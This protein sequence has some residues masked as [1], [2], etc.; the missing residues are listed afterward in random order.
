MREN[1]IKVLEFLSKD[2]LSSEEQFLL[3]ELIKNDKEALSA[4]TLHNKVKNVVNCSSHISDEDIANYIL[5]K[6]NVNPD[7]IFS[8]SELELIE[9]HLDECERCSTAFT[10]LSLE[11]ENINNMFTAPASASPVKLKQNRFLFSFKTKFIKYAFASGLA[12]AVLCISLILISGLSTPKT[13]E[14]A[15]VNSN[16]LFYV[17][18]GRGSGQFQRGL[19]FLGNKDF[20]DAAKSFEQDITTNKDPETIF[21][22][23]YILGLTYLA[24][25]SK[26]FVGLFPSYDKNKVDKAIKNFKDCITENSSGKF[27]DITLNSYFYLAKTDLALNKKDEAKKYL[28]M[29]I[30]GK[31]SKMNEANKLLEEL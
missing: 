7:R 26:S 1:Y 6:Q 30:D 19:D 10:E 16:S 15:K 14:L 23:H 25:S 9:N 20:Q 2:E 8:Q 21:Y 5:Y 29:V 24:S 11:Y 13:I 4:Y 28:Q 22:A 27:P 18:R 3:D 12:F 17:T 31:G